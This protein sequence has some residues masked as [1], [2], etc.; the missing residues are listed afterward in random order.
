MRYR[1]LIALPKPKASMALG[2]DGRTTG[3]R[4]RQASWI[5][6]HRRG[7]LYA[8]FDSMRHRVL[9][10]FPKPKAFMALGADRYWR[11][12][13]GYPGKSNTP[14]PQSRLEKMEIKPN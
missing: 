11:R 9:F 6:R 14:V 7:T 5:P 12:D 3:R 13:G 2:A 4:L 8:N 1:I 10:A